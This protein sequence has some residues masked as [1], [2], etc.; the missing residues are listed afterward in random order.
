MG[1]VVWPDQ[2]EDD[3][4]QS[5]VRRLRGGTMTTRFSAS[6]FVLCFASASLGVAPSSAV[7]EAPTFDTQQ[8]VMPRTPDGR[9]DLQGNWSNATL[10]QIQRAPGLGPILTPQQVAMMEG[11]AARGAEAGSAASDPDREAPPTGGIWTGNPLADGASGGTGGYNSVYIDG[12]TRVAVYNGQPRSS[13]ITNP[14]NGRIPPLTQ[15]A[16]QRAAERRAFNSQFGEFDNPE[17]R[18]LPERCIMSYGSNAGP[19][20]LPNYFYNNNYTIVQTP[21]H[22]MIMTEMVHDT[23]IIRLGDRVPMPEHIRPWMGDSW[24]HWEGDVLVVETTNL[25]TAQLNKHGYI[26]PG[27]SEQMKVVERFSRADESTINYEFTVIDPGTYTAEWGGEVPM[28][29]LNDLI[30]EYACAEGNYALENILSGARYQERR[31]AENQR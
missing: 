22:I 1:G 19:P 23:R 8:W 30:Y 4:I 24:G 28:K 2:A 18:G 31:E 10:T 16:M 13:L 25:P 27:G 20:M 3:I 15:E 26:Y 17:N 14:E 9:P 12:G 29:A 11:G 21:D 7:A 5:N 6:L